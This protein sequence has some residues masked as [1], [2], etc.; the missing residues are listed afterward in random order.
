MEKVK[1]A[2]EESRVLKNQAKS[3]SA[4]KERLT[5]DLATCEA[6][7]AALEAKSKAL[8]HDLVASRVKMDT[9]EK[10]MQ[11]LHADMARL[12]KAVRAAAPPF[13]PPHRVFAHPPPAP[14]AQATKDAAEI[15]SLKEGKAADARSFIE[16]VKRLSSDI[17]G[18][19]PAPAA[20]VAMAAA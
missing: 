1:L 12:T 16:D 10:N 8:Q 13:F 7:R 14:R 5:S 19:A 6:A 18:A 11:D 2:E 20:D 15:E 9:L 17:E 3:L 4:D